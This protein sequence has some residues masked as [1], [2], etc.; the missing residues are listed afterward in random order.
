MAEIRSRH[1]INIESEIGQFS[2]EIYESQCEDQDQDIGLQDQDETEALAIKFRRP[3][4][5]ETV[6]RFTVAYCLSID[7]YIAA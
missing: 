3:Y 6:L 1:E 7:I 4:P 2:S 5:E